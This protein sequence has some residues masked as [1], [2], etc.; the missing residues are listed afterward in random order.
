M[1]EGFIK[2][3]IG[4]ICWCVCCCLVV[5]GSCR[6]EIV[7]GPGA[8]EALLSLG[9]R[10]EPMS[11][12][13]T[14]AAA[15]EENRINNWAV[16]IFS[17]SGAGT[18]ADNVLER[19][20]LFTGSGSNQVFALPQREGEHYV[21]V[22]ANANDLL[23]GMREGS[24]RE[25]AFLGLTKSSAS[26]SVA[27]PFVMCSSRIVLSRLGVGEFNAAT[28]GGM[29]RVKRNV[30]KLT[31]EFTVADTV[32]RA[33]AIRYVSMATTGSVVASNPAPADLDLGGRWD[34]TASNNNLS[35]PVYL[36]EQRTSLRDTNWRGPGFY[37]MLKGFYHGSSS[38]SYYKIALPT[39][40]NTFADIERNVHYRLRITAVKNGG[41]VDYSAAQNS[42]F[43]ND[44]SVV[45]DPDM[46]GLEGIR[47]VYTNGFYEMGVNS[48]EFYLYRD[49]N[50]Y[51]VALTDVVLKVLSGGPSTSLTFFS[52]TGNANWEF[53]SV[54]ANRFRLNFKKD[55]TGAPNAD[56][57]YTVTLRFGTLYKMIKV[58]LGEAV[59]R[60]APSV[61]KFKASNGTIDK[62]DWTP[63]DWIGLGL[64]STFDIFYF[65]GEIMN[66][67]NENIFI[68]TRPGGN[69]GDSRKV[70]LIASDHVIEVHMY[71]K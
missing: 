56:G 19:M 45:I 70:S 25:S 38:P 32:F 31:V 15:A 44:V 13:V 62:A 54:S 33:D 63:S 20:F 21:Y 40:G 41:Y 34:L 57:F 26:G 6:D 71:K 58:K 14:R 18:A 68:H 59:S 48:S 52:E 39:L 8:G 28:G 66:S 2:N 35:D 5:L 65:Y 1:K 11:E 17:K 42:V 10:V 29:V 30:A 47:E 9:C 46:T 55:G 67:L 12:V 24:S 4:N 69:A 3:T 61:H 60:T 7:L 16:L 49:G 51:T 50:D 36:F 37:L 53:K 27:P 43:A 23:G 64:N 22:V